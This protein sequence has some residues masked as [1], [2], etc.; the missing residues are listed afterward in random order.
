M[1]EPINALADPAILM[2]LRILTQKL[3]KRNSKRNLNII[4]IIDEINRMVPK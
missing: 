4:L 2:S 3:L 1:E